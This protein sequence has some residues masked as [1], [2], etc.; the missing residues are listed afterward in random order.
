[1]AEFDQIWQVFDQTWEI[2]E[3]CCSFDRNF[4]RVA[5]L[6][7]CPGKGGG[8]PGG[9]AAAAAGTAVH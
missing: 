6:F 1:M 4:R 5:E 9:V 3:V 8:Q 7:V 2:W